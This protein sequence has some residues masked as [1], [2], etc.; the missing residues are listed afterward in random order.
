MKKKMQQPTETGGGEFER[1]VGTSPT[2]QAKGAGHDRS[3]VRQRRPIE[4][5][6]ILPSCFQ[7]A[8]PAF[9]RVCRIFFY[10]QRMV[11]ALFGSHWPIT[12]CYEDL[13]GFWGRFCVFN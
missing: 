6:R 9:S 7:R 12:E 13:V 10:T 5:D 4:A 2:A 8:I 1:Y 3:V 11:F